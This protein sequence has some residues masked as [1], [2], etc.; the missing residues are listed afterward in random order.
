MCA[1]PCSGLLNT[2]LQLTLIVCTLTWPYWGFHFQINHFSLSGDSKQKK[3]HKKV[4]VLPQ[5]G[6]GQINIWST[7]GLVFLYG[8]PPFK[9]MASLLHICRSTVWIIG[10]E[11]DAKSSKICL[12]KKVIVFI[13]SMFRMKFIQTYAILEIF[14]E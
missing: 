11:S 3:T 4:V 5:L 13:S 14:I 2:L 10:C 6:V 7:S 1:L 9:I 8:V 12:F